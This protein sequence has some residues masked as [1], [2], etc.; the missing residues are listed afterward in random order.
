M[1]WRLGGTFAVTADGII[2][3]IKNGDEWH[4]RGG[5]GL[6]G[7]G[8][9]GRPGLVANAGFNVSIANFSCGRFCGRWAL[10]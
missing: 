7:G 2:S 10:S 5:G 3:F 4:E 9:C 6:R 1:L 8:G